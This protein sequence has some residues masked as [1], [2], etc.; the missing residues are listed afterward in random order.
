MGDDDVPRMQII[1]YQGSGYSF[2]VLINPGGCHAG[3][4]D[5]FNRLIILETNTG[6]LLSVISLDHYGTSNFYI[7]E[8]YIAYKNLNL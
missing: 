2:L 7:M 6:D 4:I 5:N 8:E 3:V 1:C